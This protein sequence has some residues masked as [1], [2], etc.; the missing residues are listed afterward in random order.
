MSCKYCKKNCYYCDCPNPEKEYSEDESK[1]Y[2]RIVNHGL[3]FYS[4][5]KVV[6]I[7]K[8]YESAVEI[9]MYY[10][11]NSLTTNVA[12]CDGINK[13]STRPSENYNYRIM[14]IR[15]ITK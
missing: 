4:D 12:S 2:Y 1:N 9:L 14:H 11:K 13:K 5:T 8:D 7:A 6:G 3:S 10:I 15:D